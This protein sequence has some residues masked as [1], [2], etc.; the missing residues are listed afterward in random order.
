MFLDNVPKDPDAEMK[1]I[2]VKIP[3]P[4]HWKLHTVKLASGQHISTTVRDALAMYFSDVF[5]DRNGD[6][7]AD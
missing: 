3:T 2:K 7:T 6:N 4:I 5:P 1:E